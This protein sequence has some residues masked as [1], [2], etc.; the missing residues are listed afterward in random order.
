MI[1]AGSIKRLCLFKKTKNT[2]SNLPTS[3]KT[4]NKRQSKG[5]DNEKDKKVIVCDWA[6]LP[7]GVLEEISERLPLV[8]CIS[9]ARVCKPWQNIFAE[10]PAQQLRGFPWLMSCGESDK[11]TRSCF[12]IF[13]N[14]ELE[15]KMAE[16]FEWYCWGSFQDWLILAKLSGDSFLDLILLNPF[17]KT[18]IELPKTIDLYHKMVLSTTPSEKFIAC[19][20]GKY[21]PLTV[22]FWTPG[23]LRWHKLTIERGPFEDAVFCNGCLYLLTSDYNIVEI[24]TAS[25]SSALSSDDVF[26]TYEIEFQ[27]YEVQ[28]Q[29]KPRMTEVFKYL[30]ESC[31][32]VLLICRFFSNCRQTE[33]FEI[34]S[35]DVSRLVWNKLSS[36]G[37]RV[38]F[39]GKCCSRFFS[40]KELKLGKANCIYCTND[41]VTPLLNEPKVASSNQ[42]LRLPPLEGLDETNW[43]IFS[44]DDREFWYHDLGNH[45]SSI[46]ITAPLWWYCRIN[47][48]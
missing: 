22:A 8:D 5:K 45:R 42:N 24:N 31:G 18:K 37:N 11:M 2:K 29:D 10:F 35:W 34:Y 6:G 4:Q 16:A 47:K 3:S 44:L 32:E 30:V 33:S 46:W 14:L 40:A 1:C 28:P 17:S 7:E 26:A 41:L 25:I 23:T 21:G 9:F 48:P 27:F 38:L 12:S 43:S 19:M 36:L 20:L 13:Q 15:F 39:L